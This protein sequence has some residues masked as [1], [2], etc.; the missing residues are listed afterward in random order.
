M[1][2]LQID[3]SK[4][5]WLQGR[6]PYLTLIAAIDDA[7]GTVP[8]A[9]FRDQEDAHGYLLMLRS[10]IQ[11]PHPEVSSACSRQVPLEF[12]NIHKP[13]LSPDGF[14]RLNPAVQLTCS[15]VPRTGC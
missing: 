13:T 9:L 1:L 11:N 8:F 7:T 3:G 14:L 15:S 12:P 4:H 5:D 6:G 10:I 2:L